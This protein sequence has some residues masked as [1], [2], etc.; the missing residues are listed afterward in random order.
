MKCLKT[1]F[2]DSEN[3]SSGFKCLNL[4]EFERFKHNS[5]ELLTNWIKILNEVDSSS[6]SS[7]NFL[8]Q[9]VFFCF[10]INPNLWTLETSN[11]LKKYYETLVQ[12]LNTIE[13]A[14]NYWILLLKSRSKL[15]NGSDDFLFLEFF[16]SITKMVE[17]SF[18]RYR[19]T[20]IDLI[21]ERIFGIAQSICVDESSVKFIS[22]ALEELNDFK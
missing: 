10:S 17:D 19:G 4:S 21:W 7:S 12:N 11:I 8:N 1:T 13:M 22:C 6:S 9:L 18:E 15:K 3:E 16:Q 14:L 20:E 5:N 2:S